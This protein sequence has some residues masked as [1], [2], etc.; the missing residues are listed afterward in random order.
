MAARISG[1]TQ[2]VTLLI[3]STCCGPMT[4]PR[5]RACSRSS[6]RLPSWLIMAI[7]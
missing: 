5:L 7:S 3:P 1:S 2:P 4:I 6:S